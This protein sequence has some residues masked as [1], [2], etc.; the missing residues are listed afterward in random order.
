MDEER[1]SYENEDI[2]DSVEIKER[3]RITFFL[4]CLFHLQN[5]Y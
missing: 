1:V 5:T 2:P 4:V 3:K